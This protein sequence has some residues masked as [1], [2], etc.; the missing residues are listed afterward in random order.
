[1]KWVYSIEQK[2][3]AALLLVVVLIIVGAK[4]IIDK[5][6]MSRM[7]ASFS[8]VYED[9]LLVESYIFH[10][11][12]GLHAQKTNLEQLVA[13]DPAAAPA[14]QQQDAQ[15]DR[16]IGEY[17]STK[18]TKA[19]TGIFNAFKQNMEAL[20]R[21]EALYIQSPGRPLQDQLNAQYNKAAAQLLELSAIQLS[22]GHALKEQSKKIVAS[23]TL[24][25]YL[26]LA[27]LIAI[28][29]AVLALIQAS[30]TLSVPGPR[31]DAN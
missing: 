23:S 6:N 9:R 13:G 14:M 19:E 1:M 20:K 30:R 2:R 7:G 10:L 12:E 25:T 3:K 24:L 29:G 4:N 21:T 8:A 28:G 16:L 11:S 27:I 18:F 5:S 17:E 15:I 31:M 26:E 22:E